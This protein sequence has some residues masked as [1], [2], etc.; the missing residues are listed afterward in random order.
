M[1]LPA[2]PW[3]LALPLLAVA[4]MIILVLVIGALCLLSPFLSEQRRKYVLDLLQLLVCL[5][6]V[7]MAGRIT[8]RLSAR[9]PSPNE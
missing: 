2:G 3:W 5:A 9:K 7:L 4:P 8:G 6:A 1:K